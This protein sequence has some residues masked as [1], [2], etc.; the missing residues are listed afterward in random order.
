MA[1]TRS[2]LNGTVD[3][4]IQPKGS[5]WQRWDPGQSVTQKR[6]G[7][8]GEMLGMR[9]EI[10]GIFMLKKRRANDMQITS[11]EELRL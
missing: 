8:G 9:M 4:G 7:Q 11:K 2:F 5:S 1:E 6:V 10:P 3:P